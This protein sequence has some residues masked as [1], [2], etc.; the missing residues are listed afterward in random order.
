[1]VWVTSC[2]QQATRCKVEVANPKLTQRLRAQVTDV[3]QITIIADERDMTMRISLNNHGDVNLDE[4]PRY[5]VLC[6]D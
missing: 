3:F 4:I 2:L 1:M 5:F 6:I